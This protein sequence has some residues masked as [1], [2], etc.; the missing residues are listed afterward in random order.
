MKDEI[1]KEP[2]KK[3]FEFDDFVVSVFDDMIG[4]SVPCYDVSGKL[5]AQIL[6]KILPSAARVI[7]LGCST[8]TSLLLLWQLR[9]DLALYGIDS[10]EAMIQKAL[11]KA[12][13]YGAG[14]D[15]SVGD[16]LDTRL[17]EVDCVMMNYTLQFI[18]PPRRAE[19]VGK[20]Y[21]G[22]NEGGTF[23]FSE[24]IIFEDKKFAK[25]MIEIYENYKAE[26]GYTRFEIAQKREALEN[27]LIP[28]TEAENR[29]LALDAG[30][31]RVESVFK[32]GNFMTFIAFK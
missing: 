28:Y 2:I 7:D 29:A 19:L 21:R 27:V 5:T 1:F 14:L 9:G 31:K 8:A 12:R 3:Q 30:F 26:Q 13:A 25:N 10:S 15:L 4:R 24:K 6:A 20:I 16:A 32:W 17:A 23:V 18:R 22:L 11:N